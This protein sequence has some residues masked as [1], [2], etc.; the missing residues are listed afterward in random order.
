MHKPCCLQPGAHSEIRFDDVASNEG[1]PAIISRTW[2]S[3]ADMPT[4][5][6]KFKQFYSRELSL[7]FNTGFG[8][9]F[10]LHGH[11]LGRDI[12]NFLRRKLT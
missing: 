11:L 7:N 1:S 2:N 6:E 5:V 10:V 12:L 9:H 8:V 3:C 4:R